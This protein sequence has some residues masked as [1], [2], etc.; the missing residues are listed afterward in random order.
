MRALAKRVCA[1]V[2]LLLTGVAN[3]RSASADDALCRAAPAIAATES[4]DA[5]LTAADALVTPLDRPRARALYLAILARDPR[6]D[7]ATIGLAR[8]DAWDGCLALAER[9]YREV[10]ARSP[11]NVEARAGLADV[12]AW[13]SRWAE[14]EE[15]L[16][17]GLVSAP[18][19]PE[20]LTRRSKVASARGNASVAARYMTEAERVT[21]LDAEV[22]EA[23][24]RLFLGQARLGQRIER[25]PRGYDDV[26]TT[27]VSA[28]QRWRRLR[29]EAGATVASRHGALRDTRS[30]L[31]KTSVIDGRPSLGTFY[32]YDGGGWVGAAL[33]VGAPALAL[34]RYAVTVSGFQP[35][36]RVLSLHFSTAYWHY[37]DDRDVVILSPALGVALSD[38]VDL[39]FHYWLT[40]VA[41]AATDI[42]GSTVD[43]V[44]SAGVRVGWR[45]DPRLSL[46]L[47]Y[48]YGVQLDRNPTATDLLELRSHIVT[49]FARKLL[50]RSFGVDLAVSFERRSSRATAPTVIGEVIEA[51]V[52]ARW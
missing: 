12:L 22:R 41:V 49:L 14:A 2:F 51:G 8:V 46:G 35:L 18:L 28:M 42:T 37:I 21:P 39:T 47:D 34:P 26:Y 1:S 45:P 33:G 13:T 6:D 48:T 15:V 52:F 50:D 7:E 30:G 44:H 3:A 10:L 31:Q 19:S 16:S 24:D 32:H 25:F 40:V 17:T 20:L 27:D 38:A 5:M 23:R 29:F 4:T 9:G 43:Y 11:T 36:T